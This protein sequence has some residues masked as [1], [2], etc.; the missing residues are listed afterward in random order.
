MR[1]ALCCLLLHPV[2]CSVLTPLVIFSAFCCA[3]CCGCCTGWAV[4]VSV[5]FE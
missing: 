1:Y 4:A 3:C 5:S 2:L